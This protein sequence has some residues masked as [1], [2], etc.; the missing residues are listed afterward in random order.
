MRVGLNF[1]HAIPEIGGGWNYIE[2]LV[3]SLGEHDQ[4]NTYVAFVTDQ[5]VGLVPRR[6]N[7]ETVRV[8][9]NPVSR[10]Q[11][12]FYE[13]S[14]LQRDVR[15]YQLDL[16]HWFANTVAIVNIVPAVV[17][18]YDLQV[19][20]NSRAFSLPRRIYLRAMFPHAVRY[21]SL[22]LPMSETTALALRQILSARAK[23][24]QVIPPIIGK[25]FR[26]SPT[27]KV[28]EFRQKYN[29]PNEFW[30][31]VAH[32][33]PHKNHL[34]LLQSYYELKRNGFVPWPLVL[35]GDDHGTK[36]KTKTLVAQLDLE[37]DVLFLPRLCEE[38]LPVLYSAAAALVF[39][40][41][42]EG[43]GIPV[44]EA[45]ACGCPVIASDI[46]AVREFGG[47]AVPR[48]D[49]VD[50][51]SIQNALRAFQQDVKRRFQARQVGLEQVRNNCADQVIEKLMIAYRF[52]GLRQA[53]ASG[54]RDDVQG[55]EPLSG[56]GKNYK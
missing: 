10:L 52:A 45:M 44:L 26:P 31:Y 15:K 42:Y 51:S 11:R 16:L 24:I 14:L 27:H 40:S 54:S 50:L 18:I 8:G 21:A 6:P 35:R 33:Y 56:H 4:E 20:E 39:P 25:S 41:L 23:H 34:R 36:E 48:F 43:G 46:S 32:F 19:F 5:S 12:V 49:P 29:L 30:L 13:N 53:V 2:R 55:V 38:E 28:M 3:Q 47:A 9:I 17:T 1:L 7:F 37:N 22:L